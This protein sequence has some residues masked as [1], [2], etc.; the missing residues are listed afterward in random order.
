MKEFD[1]DL[2]YHSPFSGGV[3]KNMLIPVIA[4]QAELKG[5]NLLSSADCLNGKWLKHLNENL[6]EEENGVFKAREKEVFFVLGTEVQCSDKIHH[7]I[8]FPDFNS[9]TEARKEFSKYTNELDSLMGGRP[10][11]KLNAEKIA[12]IV[13]DC[14]GVIGPAHAFTPY[15]GI[16]AFFDS[17]RKAYGKQG[18][19]ISFIEL[20]LSA[21]SFLADKI[22]ENR[23]YL[24]LSNSDSH[25]PWPFRLGR[26]FNRIKLK[27]ASFKELK[28]ALSEKE[29]KRIT[30]NVGL[31]PKE[32]KYHRTA[33]SSCYLKYSLNEAKKLE[34]KCIECGKE[35]KRGVLER[36]EMLSDGKTES[37]EFRPKYIHLLP[38]QEIIQ[39][40]L[41]TKLITSPKVQLLWKK[42]VERFG[43]EI[44]VLVDEPIEEL[45][46]VDAGI[47]DKIDCFR[48]GLILFEEGGGGKY[49]KPIICSNKKE[50]EQKKFELEQKEKKSFSLQQKKL[51]EF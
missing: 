1:S 7:I 22:K 2:H 16:Y 43:S 34:W 11:L 49:G 36:I 41:K 31:N 20:G 50:L 12:E 6:I 48:Q 19:K 51:F 26:E 42:F 46:K 13:F 3:S 27:K 18:K 32:G 29:E 39:I 47:A 37:P 14:K 25:S 10:R 28:K 30:L 35:I 8:F 23:S 17:V 45:K 33:C 4:E 5:L 15:F 24:F 9:I 38:L 21:D 40:S 44:N